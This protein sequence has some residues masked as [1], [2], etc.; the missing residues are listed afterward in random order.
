[1]NQDKLLAFSFKLIFFSVV[2]FLTIF[3]YFLLIKRGGFSILSLIIFYLFIALLFKN[4]CHLLLDGYLFFKLSKGKTTLEK[5]DR[6]IKNWFKKDLDGKPLDN[7][8][9]NCIKLFN[10]NLMVLIAFLFCIF[11]LY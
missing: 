8:I 10:F 11:C 2:N 3:L 6:L 7:R 4:G 5:I 1:M 9:K